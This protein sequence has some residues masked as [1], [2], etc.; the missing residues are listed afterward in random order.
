MKYKIYIWKYKIEII[1]G[2]WSQDIT[3]YIKWYCKVS[4]LRGWNR[5]SYNY[6]CITHI[7]QFM[8]V[9][10]Y[11]LKDEWLFCQRSWLYLEP[12]L[13]APGIQRQLPYELK[14]FIIVDRSFREIMQKTAEVRTA[15]Y[16]VLHYLNLICVVILFEVLIPWDWPHLY[17]L[18]RAFM[19]C[20]LVLCTCPHSP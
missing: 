15:H 2:E 4:R 10:V 5:L 3:K 8:Y 7:T 1:I 14:I 16:H 17:M 20:V 11:F 9:I 18:P 19:I 13:S 6:R 12:I